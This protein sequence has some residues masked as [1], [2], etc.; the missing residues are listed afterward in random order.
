MD[1]IEYQNYQQNK[2]N[3]KDSNCRNNTKSKG[4]IVILD[5][6]GLCASIMNICGRYGIQIYFKGN[7]TLKNI[8]VSLKDKDQIHQKSGIIYWHM[9]QEP[10]CNDEYIGESSRTF[11]ERIKEH[12]RAHSHIYGHQTTTDYPATLDN[13]SL[14]GREVQ[15]FN[16]TIKESICIWV[17]NP[18]LNKN[19]GKYSLP[20][21]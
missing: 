15:G 10:E 19:I 20:D 9:F 12:L 17:N 7:R 4:Y 16:R 3:K 5:L 18:I 14:V 6:Q 21:I 2:P 8:L 1:T 13:F 11:G